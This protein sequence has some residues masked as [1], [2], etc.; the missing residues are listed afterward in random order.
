MTVVACRSD[1]QRAA[2]TTAQTWLSLVDTG[3]YSQS[4]TAGAP[5][6][7]RVAAEA[8]WEASMNRVRA[9]LGKMLSR[10]T[11]SA[12]ATLTAL[13]DRCVVVTFDTAFENRR[14]ATE[15]VTVMPQTDGQW[16]VAG[17]FI[18]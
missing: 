7:Q 13:N 8:N 9:P 1:G 15:T 5:Y 6:L 18:Q 2:T 16:K 4:W 10:K 12:K 17:Y 14:S 3:S 11:R